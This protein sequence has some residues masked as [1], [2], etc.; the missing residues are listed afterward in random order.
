LRGG[1]TIAAI[2]AAL[3]VSACASERLDVASPVVGVDYVVQT[4][5]NPAAHRFDIVFQSRTSRS[6]CL[7]P[8]QWPN[9]GKID[10]AFG[11]FA[12]QVEEQRFLLSNWNGGFCPGGCVVAKV[13]GGA[14]TSG[15]LRYEDFE[16]F[17]ER[18]YAVKKE[19]V[20]PASAT[21]CSR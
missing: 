13:R 12:I 11:R 20:F 15:F 14:T 2:V 16:G 10:S 21:W 6:I 7:L 4:K 18:L 17:S 19:L 3:I 5:D 9:A 8:E 1:T